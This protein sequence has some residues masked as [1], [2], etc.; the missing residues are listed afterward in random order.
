MYI[1][2]FGYGYFPWQWQRTCKIPFLS[3]VIAERFAERCIEASKGND[4]C[5]DVLTDYFVREI[6]IPFEM[7]AE[8]VRQFFDEQQALYE[9]QKMELEQSR[10]IAL[11]TIQTAKAKTERLKEAEM[12]I[13]DLSNT[14]RMLSDVANGQQAEIEELYH[15]EAVY[16]GGI[17]SEGTYLTNQIAKELG[18]S[19]KLLNER[20]HRLGVQYK[21][22]RQWLL[23]AK[24]QAKGYTK[25]ETHYYDT[26]F[27]RKSRA[28]TVWT[29]EGRKFIKEILAG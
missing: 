25:T 14:A 9:K 28:Q 1:V 20:L 18:M 2:E 15:R 17:R 11:E 19:A 22:R 7:K 21:Q 23:S 5:P 16:D 8:M 4:T 12:R 29:E 26:R 10:Q 3:Q 27:G 13:A 24:Y 6:E